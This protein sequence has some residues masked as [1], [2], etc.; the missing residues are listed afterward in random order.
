MHI[1]TQNETRMQF[2]PYGVPPEEA[3]VL[4]SQP[5]Q[6]QA[7]QQQQQPNTPQRTALPQQ[8]PMSANRL[9]LPESNFMPSSVP[10]ASM[11]LVLHGNPAFPVASAQQHAASPQQMAPPATPQRSETATDAHTPGSSMKKL[12]P[13][14][15]AFIPGGVCEA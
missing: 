7:P 4:V 13:N 2:D 8:Q 14:A 10:I 11:P 12:N 6:L 3:P 9:V 5:P 15:V 1:Y